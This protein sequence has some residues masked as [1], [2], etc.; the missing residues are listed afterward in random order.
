M[1]S[2]TIPYYPKKLLISDLFIG[3]AKYR[4]C[5][6]LPTAFYVVYMMSS[7]NSCFFLTK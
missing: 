6:L 5:F 3:V 4:K 2:I 7:Y 1:P